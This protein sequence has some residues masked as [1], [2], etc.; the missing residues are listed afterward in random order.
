MDNLLYIALE[1]HEDERNIHRRYAITLGRDLLGAWT[2]AIDCGR[3]GGAMRRVRLSAASESEAF[4]TIRA[5]LRRRASAPR[6]LGCEYQ[7]V[8]CEA[9]RSAP[10]AEELAFAPLYG[11]GA[12]GSM[13]PNVSSTARGTSPASK[14]RSS[15][16]S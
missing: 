3:V 1:A 15:T 6:R 10:P 2:V 11:G 13:V 12:A 5:R 9:D 14:R 7:L 4:A 16:R 8:E